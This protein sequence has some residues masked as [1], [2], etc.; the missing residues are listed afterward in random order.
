[1]GPRVRRIRN[2]LALSQTAMAKEL[3]ISPSYLNLIERNQRPLTVQLIIKLSSVFK[4]DPQDLQPEGASSLSELKE[5]FSDQL[6]T[7]ELPGDQELIEVVDAAPNVAAGIAKL[8]RAYKEQQ[9]RLSDVSALLAKDHGSAADLATRL[10]TDMVRQCLEER[11]NYF[12][13]IDEAAEKF[14][15]DHIFKDPTAK[16]EPAQAL[17]DW[18]KAKHGISVRVVPVKT[19]PHL[20]RRMDRHSMRLFLSAR[21]S[22]ADRYREIAIEVSMLALASQIGRELEALN[23]EGNEAIRIARFELARYAA[24]AI[25]MPYQDFQNAA[26]RAQYD[27]NILSAQFNV[28]FEQVVMRLTNLNRPDRLGIPCFMF[29]TDQAGNM[30]RRAGTKAYPRSQF[31]GACPKHLVYQAFAFPGAYHVAEVQLP[32]GKRYVTLARTTDGLQ[33][34][35]QA[36]VR[37]TAIMLGFS[38]D[39][40]DQVSFINKESGQYP[41]RAPIEV[42]TT[43]RL[44]ER[45]GCASRAEPSI[46][47]PLGLD[48]MV[49]GLSLFDF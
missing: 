37:R 1:M 12:P 3:D 45:Q 44:C 13:L 49:A 8:Y 4:I 32:D 5:V 25:M 19:M 11:P 24:Q 22:Y 15:K 10:P 16:E 17:R 42:G 27:I 38:S 26:S 28:S 18:L 20:R 9:D 33:D 40:A 23:L 48:E 41:A 36:P 30:L 34:E 43:C 46:T 7:G 35:M 31:G 6:L 47:R 29:E 21:L 14:S 2:E 39:Y